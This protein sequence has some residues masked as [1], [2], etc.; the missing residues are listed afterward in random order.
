MPLLP[1]LQYEIVIEQKELNKNRSRSHQVAF[2]GTNNF[3]QDQ[4]GVQA[5]I[6]NTYYSFPLPPATDTVPPHRSCNV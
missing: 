3:S 4:V 5:C 1:Y 6:G 2:T